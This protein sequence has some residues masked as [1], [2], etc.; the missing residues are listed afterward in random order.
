LIRA[1]PEQCS[2]PLLRLGCPIHVVGVQLGKAR[3]EQE[4]VGAEVDGEE[5]EEREEEWDG[6]R[7]RQNGAIERSAGR[8]REREW[9]RDRQR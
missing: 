2:F 9:E 5:E 8:E 3:E 4:G 1:V 7:V 6:R